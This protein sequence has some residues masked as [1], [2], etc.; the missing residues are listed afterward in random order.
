MVGSFDLKL[1]GRVCEFKFSYIQRVLMRIKQ[2]DKT[3]SA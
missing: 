1:S 3:E 2:E